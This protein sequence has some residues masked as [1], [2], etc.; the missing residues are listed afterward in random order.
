VYAA[1]GNTDS[2]DGGQLE[3]TGRQSAWRS[4]VVDDGQ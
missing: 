4:S 1:T 3:C 2:D